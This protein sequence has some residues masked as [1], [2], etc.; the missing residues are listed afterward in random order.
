MET[1]LNVPTGI[2]KRINRT[3]RANGVSC[4]ELIVRLMEKA[5]GDITEPDRIGR[6]VQYQGRRRPEGWHVF[7]VQVRDDVYEYWLDLR[8]L[9]KMSVSLILTNAARRY[10]GKFKKRICTDNNRFRSYLIIKELI[11]DVIVWKFIWGIPPN[12]EQLIKYNNSCN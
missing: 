4:S 1:T 8:K 6:M 9:L 7:H 10:L 2:L 11:D 5:M 12:L 3:A